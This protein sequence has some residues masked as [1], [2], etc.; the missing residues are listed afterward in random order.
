MFIILY[1]EN[2]EKFFYWE[3]WYSK[4]NYAACQWSIIL[5]FTAIYCADYAVQVTESNLIYFILFV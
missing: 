2:C 4:V 1:L 5:N 3:A